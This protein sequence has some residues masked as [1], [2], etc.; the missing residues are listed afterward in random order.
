MKTL[1]RGTMSTLMDIVMM[2]EEEKERR[3]KGYCRV[4]YF[5][6][7]GMMTIVVVVVVIVILKFN[8]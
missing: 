2:N 4:K 7:K 1:F 6:R 5:T 3:I 8:Q